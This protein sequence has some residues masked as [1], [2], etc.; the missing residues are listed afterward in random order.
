MTACDDSTHFEPYTPQYR[1]LDNSEVVPLAVK[2]I[3][4]KNNIIT[5]G[6]GTNV[7]LHIR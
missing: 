2:M 6:L 1:K 5:D 3:L 7:V 4:E